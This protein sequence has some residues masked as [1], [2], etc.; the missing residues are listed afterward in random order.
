MSMKYIPSNLICNTA[1]PYPQIPRTS[2]SLSY[3]ILGLVP[4]FIWYISLFILLLCSSPGLYKSNSNGS[5]ALALASL[6]GHAEISEYL[7]NEGFDVNSRD[8]GH[9]T[10]LHYAVLGNHIEISRLLTSKGANVDAIGEIL[11]QKRSTPLHLAVTLGYCEVSRKPTKKYVH[12]V[13]I[14]LLRTLTLLQ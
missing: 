14:R 4:T 2:A 13:C 5:C 6:Y 7:L 3:L 9:R 12:W 1:Y 8:E 10:P 11:D